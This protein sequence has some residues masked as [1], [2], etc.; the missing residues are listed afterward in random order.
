[1]LRGRIR[2]LSR[3]EI[4]GFRS[5]SLKPRMFSLRCG[6]MTVLTVANPHSHE[7]WGPCMTEGFASQIL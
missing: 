7:E 1:M 6:K 3:L 2:T 5:H 4:V